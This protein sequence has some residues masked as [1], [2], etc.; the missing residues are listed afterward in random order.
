MVQLGWSRFG[1][2]LA[3][4]VIAI[5]GKVTRLLRRLASG[6]LALEREEEIEE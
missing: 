5:A 1:L 2:L 6:D 4:A 3:K